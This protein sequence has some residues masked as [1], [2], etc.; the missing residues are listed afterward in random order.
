MQRKKGVESP[1]NQMLRR[2]S[3]I[4][5]REGV[6]RVSFISTG[7]IPLNLAA[8]Q[9]GVDGGWARGRIINIVGDGSTGKTVLALEAAAY[10]VYK[11]LGVES[12]LF[13]KVKQVR[14]KYNNVEGVM[15]FPLEEMYGKKFADTVEWE[16]HPTCEAFGRDVHKELLGYEPGTFLLYIADSLDAMT[17]EA[18]A[19][20]A[21]KLA[22]GLKAEGSYGTEKAKYFSSEFFNNLCQMISLPTKGGGIRHKD[23]TLILISQVR[24]N[25]NAGLFGK[26]FYRTGGKALDFYTH[27]VVWLYMVRKLKKEYKGKKRTYGTQVRAVFDRNKSAA[28]YSEVEFPII[29]RPPRGV[30]DIGAMLDFCGWQKSDKVIAEIEGDG[31]QYGELVEQTVKEWEKAEEKTK[32]ERKRKYI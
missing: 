16:Q 13:P 25:L 5:R 10:C 22:K 15:D 31:T 19:L 24:E 32:V 1:P 18:G 27:Q 6:E 8:S 14:I 26:K 21:E 17:S 23:V 11:M 30:D 12:P 3:V 4:K 29:I 28:P 9:K 7:C 20:R 2:H